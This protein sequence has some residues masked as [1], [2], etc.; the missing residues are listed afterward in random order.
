MITVRQIVGAFC[1]NGRFAVSFSEVGYLARRT[2]WPKLA[3]D[4]RGQYWLVTGGSGGLGRQMV[5]TALQAGATVTAVAR[6]PEKLAALGAEASAM[7][8]VGLEVE[9]C[10]FTSSRDSAAR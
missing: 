8:L 10:D 5:W 2:S 3:P 7:G 1:F 4:F 6:S 9:C